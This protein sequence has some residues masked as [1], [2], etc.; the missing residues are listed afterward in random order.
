[1]YSISRKYARNCAMS[2]AL[3]YVMTFRLTL[4]SIMKYFETNPLD[5]FLEHCKCDDARQRLA[6]KLYKW[7]C[8]DQRI[9]AWSVLVTFRK[10]I[11]VSRGKRAVRFPICAECIYPESRLMPVQSETA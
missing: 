2:V 9:S 11:I 4:A 10:A 6:V 7:L 8:R 1:M 5:L 3:A